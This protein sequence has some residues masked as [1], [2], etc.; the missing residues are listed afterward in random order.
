MTLDDIL[1]SPIGTLP[2]EW[3]TRGGT[4][5]DAL[6]EDL[7]AYVAALRSVPSTDACTARVLAAIPRLEGLTAGLLAAFDAALEGKR[8]EAT[9]AMRATLAAVADEMELGVSIPLPATHPKVLFRVRP[10][11]AGANFD[12][13]DLLHIPWDRA[14]FAGARRFSPKGVPMWYLGGSFVTCWHETRWPRALWVAA[15]R[16]QPSRHLQV[17]NF[18]YRGADLAESVRLGRISTEPS[19]QARAA[20][21]AVLWPLIAAC[22]YIVRDDDEAEPQE[23]LIPQLLMEWLMED[24]AYRGI[25]YASTRLGEGTAIAEGANFVLPATG[26]LRDGKH[27][28][29]LLDLFETTPPLHVSPLPEPPPVQFGKPLYTGRSHPPTVDETLIFPETE[30]KLR[31]LPFAP[32]P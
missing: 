11:V 2:R 5:R 21:Q 4:F 12:R 1:R 10:G 19:L 13:A 9:G 17:L 14:S 27:A 24:T 32:V 25:R 23:Y 30:A 26:P 29:R 8:T 16:L 15:T 31:A 20:S 7:E 18:G 6:S 28:E 22:A 3:R